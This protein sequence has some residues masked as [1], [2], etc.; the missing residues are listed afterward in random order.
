MSKDMIDVLTASGANVMITM[1]A[2]K[3][4]LYWH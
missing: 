4:R 3:L 1:C 2:E